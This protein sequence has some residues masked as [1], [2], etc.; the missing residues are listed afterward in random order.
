[1]RST[2]H[3]QM[4][5][6]IMK[7]SEGVRI[8]PMAAVVPTCMIRNTIKDHNAIGGSKLRHIDAICKVV[9]NINDRRTDKD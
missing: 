9:D 4:S 2:R 5:P 8:S 3:M 6:V 7:T 1:M